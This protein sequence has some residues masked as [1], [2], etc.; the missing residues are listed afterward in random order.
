[1]VD[2][3][4]NQKGEPLVLFPQGPVHLTYEATL[5]NTGENRITAD[6]LVLQGVWYPQVEGFC[7]FEPRPRYLPGLWPSPRLTVLSRKK[8][9]ARPSFTLIFLTPSM[10]LPAF[11]WW[12]RTDSSLHT[13]PTRVSSCGPIFYRKKPRW[14]LDI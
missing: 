13:R 11:P 4:R 7:R 14:R 12:L 10:I 9:P 8:K 3:S 2:F 6:G 5:K 1:M